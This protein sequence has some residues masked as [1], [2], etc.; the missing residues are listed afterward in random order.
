[1]EAEE[2]IRKEYCPEGEY[3]DLTVEINNEACYAMGA[4]REENL[5]GLVKIK[6]LGWMTRR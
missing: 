3:P 6:R 5:E 4:R 1:M 2:K